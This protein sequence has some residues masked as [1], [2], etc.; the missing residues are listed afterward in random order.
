MM[1]STQV[2]GGTDRT[3]ADA[4]G[5]TFR[6]SDPHRRLQS[7]RLAQ[8]VGVPGEYLDFAYR[9]RQW[10]LALPRPAVDR[11]EYLFEVEDH[12]EHR[13]TVT[14]PT[15]PVRAPGAF[16][17][18]SVLEFPE[19]DAPRWLTLPAAPASGVPIEVVSESLVDTVGGELWTIGEL[20]ESEPAPLLVAH[21]GP[22]YAR[23]GALTQYLTASVRADAL[24][25]LRIALLAPGDRNRWYGADPS[26]ARA[27]CDQVIPALVAPTTVRIGLGVSL[28]A[29]AVLHAHRL[30][31][32]DFDALFLQSGSF[33]TPELDPQEERFSRF[34]PVTRF[35]ADVAQAITDPHPVP[36]AM[37]CGVVEENLANNRAM[38]A[39]LDR[40]GYEVTLD[41]YRDAHNYVAWRDALDPTLT[42][43]LR[44]VIGHAA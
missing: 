19:Y 42:R 3:V 20:G 30:F 18:K 32:G 16:G 2:A 36:V 37:T 21:D 6:L 29:L 22:E 31:P 24:P 11:M 8:Q 15:N 34:E 23:L 17:D 44:R 1:R 5:V 40:L 43:L 28:G 38:A 14:D 41:E 33:F 10:Q 35:V 25:A 13:E 27:L 39:A 9:A 26:Y 7:V 12:N 4:D